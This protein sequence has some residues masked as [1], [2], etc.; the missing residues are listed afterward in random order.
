VPRYFTQPNRPKSSDSS[1]GG[2]DPDDWNPLVPSLEVDDHIAV[3]TGIIDER[4]DPIMR[5][6]N[7]VGF[8]RDGEWG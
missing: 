2:Y 3:E 7:P 1:R 6:P 8:G 5:A 4:G